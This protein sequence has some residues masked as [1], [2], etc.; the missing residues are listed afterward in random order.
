M[1][2][3][4]KMFGL[5][6]YCK[7]VF[8]YTWRYMGFDR[9][10]LLFYES[11]TYIEKNGITLGLKKVVRFSVIRNRTQLWLIKKEGNYWKSSGSDT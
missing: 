9:I 10:G 5:L 7:E 6:V 3:E 2:E 11:Q 8:V 1:V 4:S